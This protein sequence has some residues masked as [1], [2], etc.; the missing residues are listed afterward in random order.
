LLLAV[1]VDVTM[2]A[3][4]ALCKLCV[5]KEFFEWCN[6]KEIVGVLLQALQLH[7]DRYSIQ[8]SIRKMPKTRSPVQT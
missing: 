7:P 5:D 2:C 4:R 3:A 6:V 8:N 1:Q